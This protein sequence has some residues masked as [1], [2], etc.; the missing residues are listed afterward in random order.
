MD[1]IELKIKKIVSE[2]LGIPVDQIDNSSAFIADLGG[3]SLDT[4]EMVL[5]LEDRFG[6]EVEEEVAEELHT[7]QAVIDLVKS[8]SA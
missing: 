7:V 1:D 6:F 2:Q 5:T 8:K 3:D 4:V